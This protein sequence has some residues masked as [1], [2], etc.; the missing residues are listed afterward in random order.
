MAED[1]SGPERSQLCIGHLAKRILI[2]NS[3]VPRYWLERLQTSLL[4]LK[5]ELPFSL[6][7][8]FIWFTAESLQLDEL[9]S[10]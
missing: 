4:Q 5:F 7:E 6:P 2:R 10:L 3:P 1:V 8:I 9:L